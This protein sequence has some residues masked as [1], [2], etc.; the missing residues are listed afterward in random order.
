MKTVFAFAFA[1]VALVG[2]PGRASAQATEFATLDRQSS[3]TDVGASFDYLFVN[4]DKV[5]NTSAYRFD[6]F[7]QFVDEA[8]GFGGYLQLP[9]TH[10]SVEADIPPFAIR[11]SATGLGD[12][13]LGG[14]YLIRSRRPDTQFVLHAGLA[15]PTNPSSNDQA[16]ASELGGLVRITDIAQTIPAGTT[17]RAGFSPIWHRGQL[18]ARLD[19]GLDFNLAIASNHNTLPPL[20]KL[21]GG[22]GFANEQFAILGELTNTFITGDANDGGDR[23]LDEAAVTVKIFLSEVASVSA[24]L[25]LPLEEDTRKL[26]AAL[27]FGFVAKL[28]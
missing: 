25:I 26:D 13:E 28:R 16:A 10:A 3:A 22:I 19:I 9:I 15:L 27:Q 12:L 14:I 24:S 1:L 4:H 2:T 18:V 21:N 8:S 7:G 17:L 6:V 20:L 11:G 23:T 5:P